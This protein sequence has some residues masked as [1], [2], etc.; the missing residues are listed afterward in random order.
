M[1]FSDARQCTAR[2]KSTGQRCKNPAVKGYSVCRLHGA[3]PKNHGG[4]PRIQKHNRELN[5]PE[6]LAER[7]KDM[8]GNSRNLRHGLYSQRKFLNREEKKYHDDLIENIRSTYQL[9]DAA[10]EILLADLAHCMVM[11]KRSENA[12]FQKDSKLN[13]QK[14]GYWQ[15]KAAQLLKELSVRRDS[16]GEVGKGTTPQDVFMN[17]V[18]KIQAQQKEVKSLPAPEGEIITIE[19]IQDEKPN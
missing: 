3:N 12:Y 7:S 1:A 6:R 15:G 18:K 11:K 2:S 9:D 16:R 5:S 19:E 14:W 17:L 8:R 4:N 13:Y 10:D